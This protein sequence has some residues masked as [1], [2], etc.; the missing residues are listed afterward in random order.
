MNGILLQ[1]M[2]T[3]NE[4]LMKHSEQPIVAPLTPVEVVVSKKRKIDGCEEK[5]KKKTGPK[6]DSSW[7]C[8]VKARSAEVK[9]QPGEKLMTILGAEWKAMSDS[10]KEPYVS[11]ATAAAEALAN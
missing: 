6:S 9:L 1:A 11:A 7:I 5:K 2:Q 3:L 8:F 10:E 4:K